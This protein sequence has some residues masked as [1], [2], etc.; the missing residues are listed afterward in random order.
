[1]TAV[2]EETG[3]AARMRTGSQAEHTEAESS[4]FMDSLLKGEINERGYA[5]YLSALRPIYA[6]LENVGAQL[7]DHPVVGSIID[8]GL[9]R[10]AS[11]DADIEA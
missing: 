2:V 6:A 10:L 4:T 5:D 9:D 3:L 1:M 8:P 7:A 11:I